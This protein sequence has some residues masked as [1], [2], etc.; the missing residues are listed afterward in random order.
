[1]AYIIRCAGALVVGIDAGAVPGLPERVR[2]VDA[3]GNRAHC[4]H[5]LLQRVFVALRNLD[6]L[7]LGGAD[8]RVAERAL[9]VLKNEN[10]LAWKMGKT[11]VP[12]SPRPCRGTTLRC[13]VRCR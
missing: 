2:S 9:V 8:A 10:F 1:M 12:S 7:R 5:R 3:H 11:A 6:V 13:L 4:A